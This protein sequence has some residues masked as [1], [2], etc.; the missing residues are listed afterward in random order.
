[1]ENT[2]NE[3]VKVTTQS[4]QREL[5]CHLGHRKEYVCPKGRV[6]CRVC[7]KLQGKKRSEARRQLRLKERRRRVAQRCRPP[8]AERIWAAGFFEGEG[9]VTILSTVKAGDTRPKVSM[10]STDESMVDFF[11]AR[12]PGSRWSYI[13][14]SKNGLARRAFT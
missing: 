13:P 7:R 6:H 8:K 10:T 9:T 12:W 2:L 3:T 4:A 11:H 14:K 5:H 1:M